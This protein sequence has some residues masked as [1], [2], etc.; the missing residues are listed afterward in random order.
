MCAF[1]RLTAESGRAG[2]E[3]RDGKPMIAAI[4]GHVILWVCVRVQVNTQWYKAGSK[5]KTGPGGELC[6]P[7]V[8]RPC[9]DTRHLR[10]K[11]LLV[12]FCSD[13]H[14]VTISAPV[15]GQEQITHANH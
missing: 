10:G 6:L 1:V 3:V 11:R 12:G 4:R 9:V 8:L 7:F 15:H 2:L 5:A 13:H 14:V